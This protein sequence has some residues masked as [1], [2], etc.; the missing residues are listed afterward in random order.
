MKRDINTQQMTLDFENPERNYL[1]IEQIIAKEE[2]EKQRVDQEARKWFYVAAA[3]I[4]L[5]NFIF[6]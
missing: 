2:A 3:L 1:T 5:S 4:V 6:V